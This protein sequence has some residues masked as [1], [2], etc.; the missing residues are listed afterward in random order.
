MTQLSPKKY[1]Q[2]KARSLP[3]YKCLVNIDWEEAGMASVTVTRRHVNGRVTGAFY[4]VDLL[5]TGVKRTFEFFNVEE[6]EVVPKLPYY[7]TETEEIPYDLAHNIVYA[8]VEFAAEFGIAPHAD[9]SLTRY[10]LEPDTDAVPVIEIEVGDREDGLPHLI[11][12]RAGEFADALGKLRKNAGEGNYHY[13]V[14][15]VPGSDEEEVGPAE[16]EEQSLG[17]LDDIPTGQL[18]AYEVEFIATEDLIDKDKVEARTMEE[19]VTIQVELLVRNLG[20]QF[21]D[22]YDASATEAR[23]EYQ[24]IEAAT[25]LPVGVAPEQQKEALEALQVL[26]VAAEDAEMKDKRKRQPMFLKHLNQFAANP[27]VVV[28]MYERSYSE[29]L[30]KAFERSAELIE[31]MVDQYPLAQLTILLRQLL[32]AEEPEARFASLY[33]EA[34]TPG[35]AHNT[36]LAELFDAFLVRTLRSLREKDL[37]SAVYFYELATVM[38]RET[39]F[40]RATQVA[41]LSALLEHAMANQPAAEA[42]E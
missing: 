20:R 24:L 26:Y 28:E 16:E 11:E 8:G 33:A 6:T 22:L 7:G 29:E 35:A 4:V 30:K 36:T 1:I 39:F 31:G 25:A 23:P 13:T 41:L 37:R 40:F 27:L 9:F 32:A 15:P 38:Q 19:Q 5:C 3:V 14:L 42:A 17:R 34:L 12:F 21:P 10:I 2:S 18:S